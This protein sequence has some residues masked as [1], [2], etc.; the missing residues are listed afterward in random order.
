MAI[1]ARTH[2]HTLA[3]THT[4]MEHAVLKEPCVCVLR[5]FCVQ[6]NYCY[7]SICTRARASTHTCTHVGPPY[8]PNMGRIAHDGIKFGRLLIVRARCGEPSGL[9]THLGADCPHRSHT[10]GHAGTYGTATPVPRARVDAVAAAAVADVV[11][12]AVVALIVI[13]SRFVCAPSASR[14]ANVCTE[15]TDRKN[16]HVS[17]IA[18]V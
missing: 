14:V 2:S 1:S 5:T 11:V 18:R 8:T 15:Q 9:D 6:S 12:G 4:H 7:S 10:H 3:H 16:T 17:L 13:N